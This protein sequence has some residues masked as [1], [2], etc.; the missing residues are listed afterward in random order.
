MSAVCLTSNSPENLPLL[1]ATH[2][3]AQGKAKVGGDFGAV[4]HLAIYP[5]RA[6]VDTI[7]TK[8][9]EWPVQ[10]RERFDGVFFEE[11]GLTLGATMVSSI[12][13]P[14]VN[15]E[16]IPQEE[17]KRLV[18]KSS[19]QYSYPLVKHVNRTE[20]CGDSVDKDRV[21]TLVGVIT[22]IVE[23]SFPNCQTS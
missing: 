4:T 23:R 13:S 20:V 18:K 14:I 10:V 11:K 7:I 5:D 9:S 21:E 3:A 12:F 15:R 2:L 8:Y 6:N 16:E 17:Y 22:E 19:D 1:L